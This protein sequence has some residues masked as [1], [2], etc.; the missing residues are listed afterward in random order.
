MNLSKLL[1]QN[2]R[3]F[4]STIEISF[5]KGL[6]LL[7]GENGCGKSTVIDAIR[8]LMNESEYSRHGV[9]PED[10][11]NSYNL[12]S[13]QIADCIHISGIFSDLSESQKVE[14]LT[15]LTE[16]FEA[17]LNIEIQHTLNMRNHY[18]Q[19][20]WGGVSSNSIFDWEPLNSIQCVYLPAL[21]D[22]ERSLKSG[23][24]SRLARLIANLSA[25]DLKDKRNKSE[26]MPL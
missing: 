22:A 7:V 5:S 4:S 3:M 2:F 21:R 8:V 15:W 6:N 25:D 10:F 12:E 20:R 26:L 13:P 18:K 11:Y 24:G 1:V 16:S 14:Y 23:R 17:K 19:R 9:S